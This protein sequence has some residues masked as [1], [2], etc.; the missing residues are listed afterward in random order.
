MVR[1]CR[2]NT[3]FEGSSEIMR[4]MI[5]REALD[6]HLNM[7]G[8]VL[9][10]RLPGKARLAAAVK[11]AGFYALW[12]PMLWAPALTPGARVVPSEE[13]VNPCVG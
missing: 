4:L 2:I 3:I 10:T 13:G 6:P 5:A 9:N 7:G 1:D 12:Y 11:S 8:P